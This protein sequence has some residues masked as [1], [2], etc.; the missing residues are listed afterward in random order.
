MT[1]ASLMTPGLMPPG[2]SPR[3]RLLALLLWL[4]AAAGSAALFA[5]GAALAAWLD[6]TA[7]EADGLQNAVL[8]DLTEIA[9]VEAL[10]TLPEPEPEPA[11]APEPAPEPEPD[12][13][14]AP[15][16]EPE[17]PEPPALPEPAAKPEPLPALM[18]APMA[19]PMPAP[20]AAPVAK[21]QPPPK[22]APKPAAKPKAPPKPKAAPK[23]APKPAPKPSAKPNPGSEV[24]LSTKPKGSPAAVA[25]W[26]QKVQGQ[27]ASHIKRKRLAQTKGSLALTFSIDGSGAIIATTLSRSSGDPDLDAAV[28]AHARKKTSVT[29]PPNGRST[30]LTLPL[31]F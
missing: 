15:K 5:A 30:T 13:E 25:K 27:L 24:T 26:K 7:G 4:P 29:A 18:P 22:P 23:S 28:L 21:V 20:V 17:P 8:I 12:P 11:P 31:R 1:P 9:P 3:R 6:V 14:P 10:T 16:R 2:P 19:A